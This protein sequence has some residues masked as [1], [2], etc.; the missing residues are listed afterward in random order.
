MSRDD[1]AKTLDALPIPFAPGYY[2]THR[3]DVFSARRV[4][5]HKPLRHLRPGRHKQGYPQYGLVIDGKAHTTRA[6][7]IVAAVFLPPKP[8]PE[9]VIRHIDGNENNCSDKN[10]RWGTQLENIHDKWAHGTMATGERNGLRIHPES[11]LRGELSSSAKLSEAQVIDIRKR[12]ASGEK[13]SHLALEFGVAKTTI[14][15]IK[16]RR[17]WK[18]LNSEQG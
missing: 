12:L 13:G 7:H 16:S 5:A 9:A 1:E 4:A 3:G 18:Q 15:M 10:L 2:V 14:S 8:F 17:N 11:V 6:H